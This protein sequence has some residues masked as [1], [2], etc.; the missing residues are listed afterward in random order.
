MTHRLRLDYAPPSESTA[1]G[2]MHLTFPVSCFENWDPPWGPTVEFLRREL[3]TT[4]LS[5]S[6]K[7]EGDNKCEDEDEAALGS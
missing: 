2:W 1:S 5:W 6:A 7:L 3:K 4:R